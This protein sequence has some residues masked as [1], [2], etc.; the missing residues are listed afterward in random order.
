MQLQ[1]TER[2]S[3]NPTSNSY[4]GHWWDEFV[5]EPVKASFVTV[6]ALTTYVVAHGN[7]GF[8]EL[9]FY[10]GKSKALFQPGRHFMLPLNL[11]FQL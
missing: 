11:H 10:T 8:I 3:P 1:L 7:T 2:S 4:D 6:T 5:L 9:E